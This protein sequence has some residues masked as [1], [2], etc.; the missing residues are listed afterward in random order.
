MKK[1]SKN[2]KR[3]STCPSVKKDEMVREL[4]RQELFRRGE[5]SFLL[6]KGQKQVYNKINQ[7]PRHIKQVC[8]KMSRRYGKSYLATVIAIEKC[9]QTP[10]STVI[11][12]APSNKHAANIIVPL[13]RQITAD[14]PNGLL[15]QLK[16]Q[17]RWQCANGSQLILG[18]FDTASES[19]RGLAADLVIV[20]EAQATNSDNFL[21]VTNSILL[22]TLLS[23]G[24]RI[25][26]VYT[27]AQ[28]SDHTL[29]THTEI[30]AQAN[31]ALFSFDIHSCPLYTPRQIEE[32]CNA[33]GGPESLHWRRE[34]LLEIVRDASN[35]CVP[36]FNEAKDTIA[37]IPNLK[38]EYWIAADI[39][40][41]QDLSA[42][43]L[44]CYD[45]SADNMIVL[46][47]AT[48]PPN[49]SHPD[50]VKAIEKLS[51]GKSIKH[52]I[53]DASGDT[54]SNLAITYGLNITFPF[55]PKNEDLHSRLAKLRLFLTN[56]K[57]K[58]SKKCTTLIATLRSAQFNTARTDFERTSL[59]GHCDHLAALLYG[60]KHRIEHAD[61]SKVLKTEEERV[62]HQL[63]Q[64]DLKFLEARSEEWW[65]E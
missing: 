42:F 18:G 47:E 10:N 33:V 31:N 34:F 5:L 3:K 29:H 35:L 17:L 50:I 54:R 51:K 37:S 30:Q 24:G 53:M 19:F 64:Q 38:M 14:M 52:I 12:A 49:S 36:E 26:L 1:L 46:D 40:G 27:P 8:L 45:W 9:L 65:T 25:I 57:L 21:Y 20:D 41:V 13:V 62:H 4:V 61:L 32:M 39:G 15:K 59:L 43:Q 7:L 11:I 6:H 55:K 2:G 23:T 63:E 60:F 44:Y 48:L 58:I 22:P 56:G 28:I 16:S